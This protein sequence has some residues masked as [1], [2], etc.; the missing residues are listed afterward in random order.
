MGQS[1]VIFA[2]VLASLGAFLFGLDIGYIAP[3]L[4][5]RSFKRDVAHLADWEES[6][7]PSGTA[8]F[9]VGIFSI[10]CILMSFPIVSSYFLDHWGRRDSIQW[11]SL[12]FLFG[13]W[14]QARA[15]SVFWMCLGRLV[16]GCA[17]GLLSTVVSL[18]QSELAP[19]HLRGGLTSLYQFMITLGILVA[20][21]L[22]IPLVVL[23]DGWRYAILLQVFPALVLLLG[24][25]LLPRSPRWLVQK[26]RQE[27][28]LAVLMKLREEA[29]AREELKEILSSWEAE[30]GTVSW[31]DMTQGR[32][33]QLLLVGIS[34]QL[35]QQ[36]VGMNAFMYFGPRIFRILK[37]NE[38]KLQAFNNAV[39]CLATFPALFLADRCG[40]RSLLIWGANGMLLSCCT[41]GALGIAGESEATAKVT[42]AAIFF[43]VINFAYGWGPI[44]TRRVDA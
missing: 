20:A 40:R 43:F 33:R 29:A 15:M 24:M 34:L 38:N 37:L 39:N 12:I 19:S 21:A 25:F 41:M 6:K 22:D 28:A 8:G 7:V 44:A 42:V 11:G 18:Y 9:V 30:D 35:L 26:G 10:G 3:I 13:C 14:L 1:T 4:E 5:C 23:E 32:T 17:I 16:S 27:E 36:L 2:S 31:K